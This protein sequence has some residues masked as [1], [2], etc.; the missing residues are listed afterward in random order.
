MHALIRPPLAAAV[1]SLLALLP[2]PAAAGPSGRAAAVE[3]VAGA[4]A[5]V[6]L[7]VRGWLDGELELAARAVF[8][9]GPS[10]G[11]WWGRIEPAL[12]LRWSPWWGRVSPWAEGLLGLA[13]TERG[14]VARAIARAGL[15]LGLPGGPAVELGAGWAGP[16]GGLEVAAGVAWDF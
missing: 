3:A 14:P 16:P 9:F 12:G 10:P 8:P 4:R 13:G 15:A 2:A 7:E 5:G 6:A 1:I 11:G